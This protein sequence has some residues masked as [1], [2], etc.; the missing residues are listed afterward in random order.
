MV[1]LKHETTDKKG[2]GQRHEISE[3]MIATGR[4][5]LQQGV[6][7][8][9]QSRRIN[10]RQEGLLYHYCIKGKTSSL[11]LESCI[12]PPQHTKKKKKTLAFHH[13]EGHKKVT[14]NASM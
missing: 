12:A 4:I 11:I 1:P 8:K 14:N 2:C 6:Q 13:N 9:R 7:T 10:T 5:I 3:I